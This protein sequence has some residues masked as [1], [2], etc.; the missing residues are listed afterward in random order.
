MI[1]VVGLTV[2]VHNSRTRLARVLHTHAC[3]DGGMAGTEPILT[4]N[5]VNRSPEMESE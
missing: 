3:R 4:Q 1:A 2:L 5:S